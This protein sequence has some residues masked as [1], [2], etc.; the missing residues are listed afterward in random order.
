[1]ANYYYNGV[2]APEL[3]VMSGYSYALIFQSKWH[4]KIVAM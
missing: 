1:M 4:F 2:F 3:P